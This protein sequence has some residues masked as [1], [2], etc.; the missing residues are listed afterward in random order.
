MSEKRRRLILSLMYYYI[1]EVVLCL[2]VH[3]VY[4]ICFSLRLI[5]CETLFL[6]VVTGKKV[7][8]TLF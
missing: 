6:S 7:W 3:G 5:R 2:F 1:V 4:Y 8:I